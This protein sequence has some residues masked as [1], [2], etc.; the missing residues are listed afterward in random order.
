MTGSLGRATVVLW[1]E[2]DRWIVPSARLLSSQLPTDWKRIRIGDVVQLVSNVVKVEAMNEYKMAG[3]KW[4]GEG[5]FY[6]ET[7]RGDQI[8]AR[9]LSPLVP[10]ALIYNRLFAWKS[11]FAVVPSELADCFV[12]NEF[13]QFIPDRSQLLAKYLYLWC[14]SEQTIKAVNS[15]S[16][17]S[18]AV[19]RNRFREEFFLDFEIPLPPLSAQRKIVEGWEAA[20]KFTTEA[21]KKIERLERESEAR[22]LADLGLS[23]CQQIALPKGFAARW[24]ELDRWGVELAW[25]E[26]Q[27]IN[28][29]KFKTKP[30]GEI[31]A[32]G[33]GGTP[34]RRRPEYFGGGIPWVKTSEV[35]NNVITTTE[36][37]LSDLGLLRS[38]AKLYPVGSIVIAMYGQGATRG[39]T[40][41][42]GIEA[43]TNQAC[44]VLTDFTDG[45][46][47]DFVWFYLAARYFDLRSAAS[48]NNQPN[49]SAE[50]VRAFPVPIPPESLQR[51][52]IDR[53]NEERFEIASL[54]ADSEARVMAAKAAL[55][56][57]ILGAAPVK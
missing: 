27:Q 6:R 48:G 10:G 18:A 56:E 40:A 38:A 41:K 5:V 31:C 26:R 57:M 13:P 45:L 30:L 9:Y 14:N 22:F 33:S 12:S 43:T 21:A 51:E 2:L 32:T 29:F 55:Q 44:L 7:V 23:A 42:L 53:V 49:L 25:R 4:Y 3:V 36:E 50:L 11:S 20:R 34:S 16:T 39:R 1:H 37:T 46:L 35:R 52:M 54:R 15:A 17:G 24:S 19:S 47:A 8:S 28:K